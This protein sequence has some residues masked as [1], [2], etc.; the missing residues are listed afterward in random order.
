MCVIV[1]YVLFL[2]N[3]LNKRSNIEAS[4]Y[5]NFKVMIN[6]NDKILATG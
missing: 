1:M 2:S 4:E 3:P 5:F 6:I